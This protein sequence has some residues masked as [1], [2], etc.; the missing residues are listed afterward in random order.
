MEGVTPQSGTVR[1]GG[2]LD[3]TATLRNVGLIAAPASVTRYYLSMDATR[4]SDDRLLTGSRTFGP[5]Q[6][7]TSIV[8]TAQVT[9]PLTVPPATYVVLACADDLRRAAES[10]ETNNCGA[11]ETTVVVGPAGATGQGPR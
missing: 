5:L 10:D 4:S 6:P 1:V 3:V 7:D 8:E 11:S 2:R 9:V